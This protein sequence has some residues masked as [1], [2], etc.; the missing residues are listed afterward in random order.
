MEILRDWPVRVISCFSFRRAQVKTCSR[1]GRGA[2]R[3]TDRRSSGLFPQRAVS[4][5]ALL[6]GITYLSACTYV[7][8]EIN[9]PAETAVPPAPSTV[10]RLESMIG[11][12]INGDQVLLVPLIDG[13]DAL[14]ARLR[15]IEEA[16]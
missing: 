1:V 13:N 16:L 5:L 12:E 10:S 11:E 9:R 3:T 15:M 4:F 2:G 14:G 8:F 7:P 6:S